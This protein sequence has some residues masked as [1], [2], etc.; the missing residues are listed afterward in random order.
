MELIKFDDGENSVI[1]EVVAPGPLETLEVRI[2]ATS[3]F[4]HGHLDE[5]HLLREDLDEWAAILD[6]LAAG[7]SGAW[8]EQG[9]GPQMTIVPVEAGDPSGPRTWTEVTV[10]DAVASLTSVTLPIRLPDDW[11]EDHRTR[12]ELARTLITPAQPFNV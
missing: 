6:T 8:M 2:T 1:V 4:A 9:R 5:V 12:L 7:G 10:T 11:I 3:E